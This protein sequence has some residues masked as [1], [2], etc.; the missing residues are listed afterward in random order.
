MISAKKGIITGCILALLACGCNNS[1]QEQ[2]EKFP[3]DNAQP[4]VANSNALFQ[5]NCASCHDPN[6]DKTGPAL[7]GALQRWDNDSAR[8]KAF[9]RNPSKMIADRDPYAVKLYEKWNKTSMTAF[10]NFTEEEL[11]SLL[12]MMK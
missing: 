6:K 3:V 8:I 12:S 4:P 9:I 5:A 11:N 1:N 2:P 10:P 7:A